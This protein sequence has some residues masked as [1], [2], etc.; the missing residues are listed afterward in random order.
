MKQNLKKNNAIVKYGKSSKAIID[1]KEDF[2]KNN[3]KL[4]SKGQSINE[5]Y[6]R[7]PVR[8]KCKNC[9]YDLVDVSFSKQ[10]VDYS[11]CKNCGH[12]N[13]LNE[14]TDLFCKKIYTDDKG[15]EY[16][17]VYDSSGLKEYKKRVVDVYIPKAQFLHDSLIEF[18][19]KPKKLKYAD[20]GAGSGYFVSALV[21]IGLNNVKGYEPSVQQV[22]HGNKLIGKKLLRQI[23][24]DEAVF[25]IQALDVQ[26]LS[27]IGVL[28]HVQNPR[29]ILSAISKNKNIKYFYISVP[30]FSPTVFF[31]MVFPNIMN[32][33]LSG[34]HTHLYTESSL[35]FMAD[36]YNFDIVASWWFGT[37]MVDL[38]RSIAVSMEKNNNKMQSSWK[39]MFNQMIDPLQLELDKKHMSSEVHMIFKVNS[40]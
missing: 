33:Q 26:V 19:C 17:K 9:N 5:I 1:L 37:D 3:D 20:F 34:A 40:S 12:L 39:D 14:D 29:E 21:D 7:Q 4:L 18:G 8:L 10:N 35:N 28:E 22:K 2:F 23:S 25:K 24:L 38:Y 32:R 27:M 11:V 16:S 6:S 36:E 13:G 31:E 15:I 30:L